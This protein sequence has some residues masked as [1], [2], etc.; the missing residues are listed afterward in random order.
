MEAISMAV[1]GGICI[2]K[3]PESASA[4]AQITMINELVSQQVDTIAIAGNDENALQPAL[5]QA[6]KYYQWIPL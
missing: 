2:I 1:L 3:A 6:K 4:E 5:G